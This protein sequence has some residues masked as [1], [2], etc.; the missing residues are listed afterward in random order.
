[1]TRF[2]ANNVWKAIAKTAKN[3]G[4]RRAAIAYVT[5]IPPLNLGTGD[6]LITD[7]SKH[8]IASGHTSASVLRE[9]FKKGVQVYSW[10]GLHA[11]VAVFDGTAVASSANL[12]DNSVDDKLLEAGIIT[13]HP[14]TVAG[15]LSFIEQLR[16][17]SEKLTDSKI[18]R[19]EKIPV[20]K[21]GGGQGRT[22]KRRPRVSSESASWITGIFDLTKPFNETDQAEYEE[23]LAEASERAPN[24]KAEIE[25]VRYGKRLPIFRNVREGHTVFRIWRPWSTSPNPQFVYPLTAVVLRKEGKRYGWVF[26]VNPSAADR[27]LKWSEFKRLCKRVGVP[28]V[29]TKNM[30][31]KIPDEYA[32]AIHDLWSKASAR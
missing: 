27:L 11:K 1:M 6:I 23:G 10:P 4:R 12:S 17:L 9:L 2:I 25:G 24:P 5:R 32:E 22:S 29:P 7:A 30:N 16:E 8:A 26:Y 28:F 3:T 18:G 31:R 13:D 19:L 15:A 20:V 21:T 14:G